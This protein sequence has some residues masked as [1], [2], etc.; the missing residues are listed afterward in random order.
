MTCELTIRALHPA[1]WPAAKAIYLEG[2]ATQNSTFEQGAPAWEQWD[3]AHMVECRFVAE[4][5]GEVLGWV[6][7]TRVSPRHVY[8]GVAEFSVYVAQSARRSGVGRA[9]MEHLVRESERA[10]IWTLHASIFPENAGSLALCAALGFR[11]VGHFEKIG[12]M[13]G[14]WRDSVLLE[15]RSPIVD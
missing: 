15:R 11:R 9:L 6:A 7:L 1:D 2:I 8:R 3:K 14:H 10:G 5:G 13:N 4:R 12:K